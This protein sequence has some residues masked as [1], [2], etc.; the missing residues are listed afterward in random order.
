MIERGLEERL[1]SHDSLSFNE[2]IEWTQSLIQ[3]FAETEFSLRY[4]DIH[5]SSDGPWS[6]SVCFEREHG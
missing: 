4:C 3:F 1:Y 6:C 2:I 5:G